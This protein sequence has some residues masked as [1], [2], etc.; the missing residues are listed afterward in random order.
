LNLRPPGYEPGE[1]PD[2]STP[3]REVNYSSRIRD[4][5]AR[6]QARGKPFAE[7]A[8]NGG[9]YT[10]ERAYAG[11]RAPTRN[12]A[13]A[14]KPTA[15]TSAPATASKMKWFPVTTIVSITADG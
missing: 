14:A 9:C 10:R 3:R 4:R 15:I 12:G 1:L 7:P 6:G 8:A 11:S 2:C 13:V 5:L